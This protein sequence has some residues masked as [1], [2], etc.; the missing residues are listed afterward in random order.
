MENL[1]NN[2]FSN[3]SS[4]FRYIGGLLVILVGIAFLVDNLN[5]GLPHWLFDWPMFL[6]ALGIF[7]GA[8]RNFRGIG[9]LVL[10]L[11]GS[12]NLLLQ[13][14]DYDF[15]KYALGV[16]LVILGA[17]LIVKP[18]SLKIGYNG[19]SR[20]SNKFGHRD[21]FQDAQNQP[22]TNAADTVEGD[23]IDAS[24]VFG[25]V[26]QGV[27]SKNFKGGKISAVFGGADVNFTQAD[28]TDSVV[29][30]INAAFGG[31]KL[32]V[33]PHWAIKTNIAPMFG[34]VE[35]K[36]MALT[37]TGEQQKL[38]I[39]EGSVTFGGVEIRSF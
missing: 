34:N 14:T 29:L 18:K 6:I 25:S 24:A 9:W 30:D 19:L 32:I 16:G 27:F 38:L 8:R 28:F 11:I 22:P 33:P 36:R 12:Y 1:Q 5:L 26:H 35:D 21:R 10:I 7:V 20:R 13:I 23:Y 2:N 15:S 4:S 17:Y 39:L 31:I 37:E 3:R